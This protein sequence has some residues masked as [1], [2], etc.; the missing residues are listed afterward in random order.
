LNG[1]ARVDVALTIVDVELIVANVALI[2]ADVVLG[3]V[4]MTC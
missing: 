4:A 3:L 2:D 1:P